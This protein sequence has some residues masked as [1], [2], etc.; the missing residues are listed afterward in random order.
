MTQKVGIEMYNLDFF[1]GRIVSEI[2]CGNDD[3]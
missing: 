3:H 2:K 1:V